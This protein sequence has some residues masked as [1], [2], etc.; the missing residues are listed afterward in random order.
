METPIDQA[1]DHF[2]AQTA[3]SSVAVIIPLFGYWSDIPNN[4]VNGEVL[5]VA[6][7]RLYS[8]VHHLYIIFVANPQSMPNTPGDPNSVANI[9]ISKSQ[10][11]NVKNIPVERDAPYT[12]YVREGMDCAINETNAQFMV[13][14]DPWVLIQEG[15][16]D[17]IVDRANRA[18]DA[19]VISGYNIRT[20]IGFEEFDNFQ[21]STP[22]EEW[23][24]NFDFLA[25]PRY[26]AEMVTYDPQYLTKPFLQI[27]IFNSMRQKGFAVI[28]SQQIPIFPFD[29]P[30][31]DYETREMFEADRQYF[32][33]KWKF[34]PGLV[35]EGK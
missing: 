29:F 28:S 22:K 5:A 23:D 19:K 12:K 15:A 11:G 27:D 32:I 1:V 2:I 4:P 7:S 6:L 10:A 20:A 8:N 9:I 18:G 24:I 34:D 16:L 13:V 31:T 17:A 30:W 35:Y 14:L 33:S 21:S 26:A 3:K 25:M